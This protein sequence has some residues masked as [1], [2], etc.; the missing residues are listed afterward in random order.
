VRRAKGRK[1]EG[2]ARWK[3]RKTSNNWSCRKLESV[4]LERRGM[5]EEIVLFVL[6]KK[7]IR[8]Y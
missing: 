7:M 4:Y 8:V 2:R 1:E 6:A 3:R 5:E